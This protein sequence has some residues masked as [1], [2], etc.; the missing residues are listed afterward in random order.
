ME[1]NTVKIPI[2]MSKIGADAKAVSYQLA[3]LSSIKKNKALIECA[4]ILRRSKNIILRENKKDLVLAEK[5]GL[6]GSM[7]D[8][9]ELN[10]DRIKAMAAGLDEIADLD[11]PVGVITSEWKRPNG[12]IIQRK[13]VPLGVIG[14]IFESRPNVTADAGALCLKAGNAV[15]LRCGSESFYSS[16][17]IQNC[18]VQ[19]LEKSGLPKKSIQLVPLK[20]RAAV[21]EMLKMTDY[22]DVIVPRGG[23][24]LIKRISQ[25]SKVP[26]FKHL[27][28]ICHSYV[29]KDADLEMAIKIVVNAKM[30]RPGICGATETVLVDKQGAK[31][32]LPSIIDGLID[33]GCEV[34][35]GSDVQAFDRRVIKSNKED[36]GKEYLD[37]IISVKLVQDVNQAIQHIGK[38]GS[39]HTDAIITQNNEVAEEFLNK[40]D[41]AIVM[42]NA[43]TQF[44]DGG[45]FGMGAEI[46]ISTGKL[47]ARGPVGIEQLTSSKYIVRGSGQCRP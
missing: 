4:N 30:R 26:I 38:Y 28:G 44:A 25:D 8:R 41:S 42:V 36:W 31:R 14:V 12:L 34:R 29:N 32:L 39:N 33:A 16:T 13:R 5:K 18:L 43:S 45:E 15:I 1:V 46:G 17:A 22:I 19:G 2:L 21:G 35:G 27:E 47:H 20:D 23:K 24:S 9:L 3:T 6:Q 40:V 10:E 11:D 7:L 37:S